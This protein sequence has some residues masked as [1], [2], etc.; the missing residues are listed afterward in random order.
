LMKKMGFTTQ[1][2]DDGTVRATLDLMEEERMVCPEIAPPPSPALTE[3][4]VTK[5]DVKQ[6]TREAATT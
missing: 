5:N 1:N 2:Q 6:Q 3:S 4:S